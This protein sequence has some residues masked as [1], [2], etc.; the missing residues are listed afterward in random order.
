ML[1]VS[2]DKKFSLMFPSKWIP[3]DCLVLSFPLFSSFFMG[4]IIQSPMSLCCTV[5]GG[6]GLQSH[7][8]SQQVLIDHFK[9]YL[10]SS[11][12]L[13]LIGVIMKNS[14]NLKIK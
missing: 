13:K 3:P 5:F 2:R 11:L 8:M 6:R 7:T 12:I 9:Q 1:F 10:V 14:K 4:G